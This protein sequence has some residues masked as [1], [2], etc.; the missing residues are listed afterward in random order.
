MILKSKNKVKS[1]YQ[2]LYNHYEEVLELGKEL[3]N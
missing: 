1:I 2:K 3:N